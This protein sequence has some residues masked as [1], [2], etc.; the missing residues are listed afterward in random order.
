MLTAVLCPTSMADLQGRLA[1]LMHD[2][3]TIYQCLE[4]RLDFCHDLDTRN[5]PKLP[6]PAIFTLRS[7][8]QGGHFQG[9]EQERLTLLEKLLA[10]GPDYLDVEDHIPADTLAAWRKQAQKTSFILSHHDF[11]GTPHLNACL[12]GMMKTLPPQKGVLYKIACQAENTL[13]ALRMLVFCREQHAL[14][15]DRQSGLIGI[16]MGEFGATTRI[17]APVVHHGI[18]YCPTE[19]KTAPGQMS[20]QELITLYN[21]PQLTPDTAIYGLLGDPVEQSQGHIFHNALNKQ[22]NKN[23]V[24][25]KWHTPLKDL[26]ETLDSL[27]TLGV[28]GLSVTMPLKNAISRHCH[29]LDPIFPLPDASFPSPMTTAD[30][31]I[32]V[33]PTIAASSKEEP[34]NTLRP[35]PLSSKGERGTYPLAHM[36]WEGLNTDG[37]GAL[38]SLPFDITNKTVLIIGAG[39]AAMALAAAFHKARAQYLVYN[40]TPKA[41]PHGHST[42]DINDLFTAPLPPHEVIINT[43]PF[44]LKLPFEQIAF[45]SQALAFDISYAKTSQ[46]LH[47]AAKA[48]CPI[49]TGQG[50]FEE[51]ALLQ[52]KFWGINNS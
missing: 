14:L 46:F 19:T 48:G 50:M 17:L 35:I 12:S 29:V 51:Q 52:R 49:L 1:T 34:V 7:P 13:D 47:Y 40:R 5:F 37:E 22:D 25:V 21:F 45:H 18:C 10:L 27:A 11:T 33:T 9:T 23:A 41:L 28:Q 20:A 16:S 3:Q 4:L 39:G 32:D 30:K 15:R 36:A 44:T 43:L 6:L 24:Y 8:Q 38:R 2:T 26:D 31:A 42:L